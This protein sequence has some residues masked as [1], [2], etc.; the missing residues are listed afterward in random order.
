QRIA[1]KRL[2]SLS[3]AAILLFLTLGVILLRRY[4][5]YRLNFFKVAIVFLTAFDLV[6]FVQ[7]HTPSKGPE[8]ADRV[9]ARTPTTEFLRSAP[10]FFRVIDVDGSMPVNFGDVYKIESV[11]GYGATLR[12]DYLDFLDAGSA[13]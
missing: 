4:C 11:S 3:S 2:T 8:S 1:A 7:A 6:S 13:P 10:G 9:Y 12:K 5:F